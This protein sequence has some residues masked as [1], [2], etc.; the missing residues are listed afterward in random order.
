MSGIIKIRYVIVIDEYFLA[1]SEQEWEKAKSYCIHESDVY[2]E[3]CDFE[4]YIDSLYLYSSFVD[5]SF[6]VDIFDIRID[7]NYASAYI[8]GDL[9]IITDDYDKTDESSGYLFLQKV[10]DNWKLFNSGD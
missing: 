6:D 2:Y 1:I 3:T 7:G 9:T 5:I 10:D 4:D 8:D